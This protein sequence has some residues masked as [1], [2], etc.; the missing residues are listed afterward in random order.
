MRSYAALD[1]SVKR[2]A[3][4]FAVALA[5]MRSPHDWRRVRLLAK[6]LCDERAL[7]ALT[8]DGWRDLGAATQVWLWVAWIKR[9]TRPKAERRLARLAGYKAGVERPRAHSREELRNAVKELD[10]ALDSHQPLTPRLCA[11]L[12][13]A[14]VF[15]VRETYQGVHERYPFY[16]A[17]GWCERAACD[18]FFFRPGRGDEWPRYCSDKC[19]NAVRVA[20]HA[21][22]L[23]E[24]GIK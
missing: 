2:Q 16:L 4:R 1:D 17:F 11:A 10:Q 19:G 22:K 3:V 15:S 21:E 12:G 5:N 20:R 9:D 8:A 24:R 23:R 13:A 7:A 18:R 6:P 14:L